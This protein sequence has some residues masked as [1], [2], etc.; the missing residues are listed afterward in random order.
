MESLSPFNQKMAS[1][2]LIQ[3]EQGGLLLK[4]YLKQ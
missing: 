2:I 4:K 1:D 3:F